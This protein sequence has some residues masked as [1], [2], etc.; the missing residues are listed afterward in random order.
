MEPLY[1]IFV[2]DCTEHFRQ[3]GPLQ[4]DMLYREGCHVLK[5]YGMKRNHSAEAI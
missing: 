5:Q 3:K 1:H 4:N 2:L